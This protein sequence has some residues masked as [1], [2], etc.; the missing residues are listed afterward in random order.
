[1]YFILNES[2]HSCASN[3]STKWVKIL[4][5]S[6]ENCSRVFDR[7]THGSVFSVLPSVSSNFVKMKRNSAKTNLPLWTDWKCRF[8]DMIPTHKLAR[9]VYNQQNAI[10]FTNITCVSF[11]YLPF[12][13]VCFQLAKDLLHPLP[14]EEK[15][16]HKLKRLVQHP[17]SYFMDVKCPG[18]YKITTVFSHAQGVVVCAGCSTI[19][20]Q[21]TGGRAKLTEGQ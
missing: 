12:C 11:T 17:N 5:N 6:V 10:N 3:E 21:P 16:K 20:C 9:I 18:C 15:R 2:A 19:L 14:A 13:F 7:S 4:K 8:S 1:M